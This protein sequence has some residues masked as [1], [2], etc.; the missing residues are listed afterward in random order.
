MYDYLASRIRKND[1]SH[2]IFYEP[3]LIDYAHM[4]AGFTHVPGGSDYNNRSVFSYHIYCGLTN[5]FGEPTN[6]YLCDAMEETFWTLFLNDIKRIGGGGM[7]TEWGNMPNG[8]IDIDAI[9]WMANQADNLL[10]SWSWWQFKSYHDIT[11]AGVGTSESFYDTD[12]R[13]M[14]NKVQALSRTYA[15]AIAG[16][17]TKMSYDPNSKFFLLRYNVNEKCTKPTEIYL[18]KNWSYSGGY[19]VSI[20][21]PDSATWKEIDFNRIGVFHTNVEN[22]MLLSVEISAT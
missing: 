12:G 13:L 3:T 20:V 10:Q 1:L 15:Y 17:P 4:D 16:I 19:S 18:N 7:L 21:P 22:G 14:V 8:T 6:L 9:E 11:T 5:R 2:I